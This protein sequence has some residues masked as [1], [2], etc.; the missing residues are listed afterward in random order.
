MEIKTVQDFKN[1]LLKKVP[2]AS[3]DID[4]LGMEHGKQT[5]T[6]D[7]VSADRRVWVLVVNHYSGR[8]GFHI[9]ALPH[10]VPDLGFTPVW[11]PEKDSENGQDCLSKV[12]D[13]LDNPTKY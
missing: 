8:W 4:R 1:E 12:V 2:S 7:V 5:D 3:C 13:V 6:L 10:R 11:P 9:N